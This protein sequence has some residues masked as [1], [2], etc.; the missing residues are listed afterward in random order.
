M[1]LN[2]NW[3]DIMLPRVRNLRNYLSDES[4]FRLLKSEGM[5]VEK[6]HLLIEACKILDKP[7]E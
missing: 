6:T 2:Q 4:I 7:I 1:T 5:E 3:F